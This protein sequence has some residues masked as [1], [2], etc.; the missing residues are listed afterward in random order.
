MLSVLDAK[1][2]L[3]ELVVGELDMILGNLNDERDFPDIVM[4][5]WLRSAGE[6]ELREGFARLGEELTRAKA[7]YL[8]SK[9]LDEQLFGEEFEA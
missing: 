1:L 7:Q 6:K 9:E 3:F 5:L 8:T 2:N 4:D